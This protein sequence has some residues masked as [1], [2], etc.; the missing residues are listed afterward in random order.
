MSDISLITVILE[1]VAIYII[2][3]AN[4]K[5]SAIPYNYEDGERFQ[6]HGDDDDNDDND[7]DDDDNDNDDDIEGCCCGAFDSGIEWYSFKNAGW[8]RRACLTFWWIV[9]IIVVGLFCGLCLGALLLALVC[10]IHIEECCE[11]HCENWCDK[12]CCSCC[13]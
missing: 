5:N 11:K 9:F 13:V 3:T 1:L 2:Y 10:A 4:L 12:H 8:L 7:G 6:Q